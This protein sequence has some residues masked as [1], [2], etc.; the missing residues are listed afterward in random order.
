MSLIDMVVMPRVS[1]NHTTT[2]GRIAT[3]Y[4]GG[5]PRSPGTSLR[6]VCP[7]DCRREL[8]NCNDCLLLSRFT[9]A[10]KYKK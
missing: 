9:A 4:A 3:E 6:L 7:V 5:A 1:V 8:V 10:K 2:N